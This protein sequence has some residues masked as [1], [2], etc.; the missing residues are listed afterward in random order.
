[1][2]LGVGLSFTNKLVNS[3]QDIEKDAI[4]ENHPIR[5]DTAGFGD[6]K[7][8]VAKVSEKHGIHSWLC[9]GAQLGMIREN[10]LLPW[11]NDTKIGYV[12]ARIYCQCL[13]YNR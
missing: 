7:L 2:P 11:K 6:A 3:L 13:S 4:D 1:M 9:Y 5:S 10:Q 12:G 8:D